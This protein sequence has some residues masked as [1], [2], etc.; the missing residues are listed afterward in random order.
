MTITHRLGILTPLAVAGLLLAQPQRKDG[1]TSKPV[2][3]TAKQGRRAGDVLT[4]A[5]LA[6]TH[7]LLRV[8]RATVKKSGSGRARLRV[9][10]LNQHAAGIALRQDM[11]RIALYLTRAAREMARE[12]IAKNRASEPRSRARTRL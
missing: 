12:I 11:P 7:I 3:R 8:A 4:R 2:Q 1:G 10:A 9:A 6:R 5:S